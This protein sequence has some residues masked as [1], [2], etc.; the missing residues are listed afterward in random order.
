[1]RKKNILLVL[2]LVFIMVY[3]SVCSHARI[4]EGGEITVTASMHPLEYH[5]LGRDISVITSEE[6]REHGFES[7]DEILNFMGVADINS[8]RPSVQ[9]DVSIRGAS[10]EQCLVLLNGI[11]LNNGQT[12]HHNLNIPVTIDQ[13]ERIE[14]MPGH[15]S[16]IYGSYGFGGTINIITAPGSGSDAEYS[17]SIGNNSSRTASCRINASCGSTSLSAGIEIRESQGFQYDTEHDAIKLSLLISR[18]LAGEGNMELYLGMHD[19]EFGAYDFYTPGMDIPSKE[20]TANTLFYFKYCGKANRG[21]L[22]SGIHFTKSFDD[23]I[24][25]L[26]NPDLY[27]NQH[28]LY[29]IGAYITGGRTISGS[30]RL[31]CSLNLSSERIDST[32]IGDISRENAA[33]AM[34]LL[35]HEGRF[36]ANVSLRNDFYSGG[37]SFISPGIG[38]YFN[39]LPTLKFRGSAG[40]SHRLPSFTELYYK[41][42]AN[43]GLENLKPEKNL[44]FETGIDWVSRFLTLKTT[45]FYRSERDF[46]EW[47]MAA[48][49]SSWHV[50]NLEKIDFFGIET[51]IMFELGN[52]LKVTLRNIL[53]DSYTYPTTPYSLKYRLGFSSEMLSMNISYSGIFG[54]NIGYSFVY[55]MKEYSDYSVSSL[56]VRRDLLKNLKMSLK[57][58]NIFDKRYEEIQ[59]IPQPG[60]RYS[61]GLRL[62]F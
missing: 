44:S 21:F 24:F 57:A 42:P 2:L 35:Y 12:G 20:N 59:G 17:L 7:I 27:R 5:L 41:D 30:V 56:S 22:R 61:L 33:V 38:L 32:N 26:E 54:F 14:V 49:E 40:L 25:T 3:G 45:V 55:K 46:I 47:I 36:G 51:L 11:L 8:R 31:S 13:I 10:F 9:G 4:Y 34:E 50:E 1:M 28:D 62:T 15:S 37:E 19:S 18:K 52:S 48:D 29:R 60:R 23:F 53:Q 16:S 43:M 39:A 6:I 58:S